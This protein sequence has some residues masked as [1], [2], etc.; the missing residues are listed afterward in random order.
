MLNWQ[1][2]CFAGDSAYIHTIKGCWIYP[3]RYTSRCELGG[4]KNTYHRNVF[5]FMKLEESM[6]GE[7]YK[8]K[9]TCSKLAV[10]CFTIG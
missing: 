1:Q 6:A 10:T 7:D 8:P 5:R 2:D 4:P 3:L 9:G